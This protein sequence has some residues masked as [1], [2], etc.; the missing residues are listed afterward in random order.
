[1]KVLLAAAQVKIC[2]FYPFLFNACS[3]LNLLFKG[4]KES[5]GGALRT[6]LTVHTHLYCGWIKIWSPSAQPLADSES[7]ISF[8]LSTISGFLDHY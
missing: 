5:W 2:K 1:M 6:T 3:T 7:E 8:M 4:F